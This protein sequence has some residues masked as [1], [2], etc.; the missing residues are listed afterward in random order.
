MA[1]ASLKKLVDFIWGEPDDNQENYDEGM[2][3]Q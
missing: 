3:N 1:G 2:Y